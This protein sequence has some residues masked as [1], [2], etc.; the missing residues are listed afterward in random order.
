MLVPLEPVDGGLNEFQRVEEVLEGSELRVGGNDFLKPQLVIVVVA[1][2]LQ[3][4]LDLQDGVQ[5][6]GK[7]VPSGIGLLN[8]LGRRN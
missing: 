1:E 6:E 5:A 3:R 8:K 2:G 4:W 7:G